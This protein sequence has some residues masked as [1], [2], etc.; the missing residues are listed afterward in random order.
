MAGDGGLFNS[1]IAV[2]MATRRAMVMVVRNQRQGTVA[3]RRM[4][5][6]RECICHRQRRG[7]GIDDKS[8]SANL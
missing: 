6:R 2:R 8:T 5:M 4:G 7:H 1:N 3:R